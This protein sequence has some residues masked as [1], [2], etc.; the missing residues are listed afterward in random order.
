[1]EKK[2]LHN[3]IDTIKTNFDRMIHDSIKSID[4]YIDKEENK[5][6][7]PEEGMWCYFWEAGEE[8]RKRKMKYLRE[9]NTDYYSEDG[10]GWNHCEICHDQW[11]P[12][13]YKGI[14]KEGDLFIVKGTDS[15][16][17]PISEGSPKGLYS[18]ESIKNLEENDQFL[19]IHRE[20]S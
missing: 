14:I 13:K 11:L 15:L 18:I 12:A 4:N 7:E 17:E 1:M 20:E 3:L 9:H 6:P 2:D 16:W 5:I 19:I 10:Q 8:V